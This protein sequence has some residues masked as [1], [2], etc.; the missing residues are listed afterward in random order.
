MR[1]LLVVVAAALVLPSAD[2]SARGFVLSSPAFRPGAAIPARF[3]CDGRD[4]SPP[5]RWTAPPARTR[6]L[7]IVMK[8]LSTAPVFTHWTAWAISSR[9]R[10]LAAGAHPPRQGRNT[11][12]RLGYGGPCPP[13]GPAHRYLFRL[14]ALRA[15]LRLPAEASVEQVERALRPGNVLGKAALLGTY[16]RQ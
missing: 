4:V 11:F 6:S 15:P 5:L 14:Y 13:G 9:T 2:A 12:D 10:A 1:A 7:A 3:T 8:D 16:R